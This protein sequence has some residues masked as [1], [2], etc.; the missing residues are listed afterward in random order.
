MLKVSD[1]VRNIASLLRGHNMPHAPHESGLSFQWLVHI[2]S[3]QILFLVFGNR[4][5]VSLY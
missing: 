2:R 3:A 1:I 5:A 4:V